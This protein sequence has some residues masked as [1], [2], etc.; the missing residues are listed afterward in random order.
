MTRLFI[1]VGPLRRF[2]QFRR[3]W[4]GY[5]FRQL[6][7]QLTATTVIYQVFIQTHS[8]IDVGL[9]SIAQLGP[10][11]L[12]PIIG[13]AIADAI[14]RR[15]LLVV[16]AVLFA[17]STTGLALNALGPRP[18]L[19]PLYVCSAIT[20]GLNG[21]DGPT[22]TAVTMSLVDRGSVVSANILRQVLGQTSNIAGPGLA[23]IL[24]ALFHHHLA[25]VYWIDA[26]S[27]VAALQAVLRLPPLMPGGGGRKFSFGSIAEGFRFLRGRQAIQACFLADFIATVLGEPIS[28][29]PYM[30]LV[31]FHGGPKAF[32]LLSASPAIGAGLGS[33][34]SGWTGTVHRPGRWVLIAVAIWGA[35]IVGFG[36]APW[37]WLGV[38]CV[39]I[40]G[41]ADATSV[42]F[43]TT[44][45]QLDVPDR[46]RGR[47]SSIQSMV[48]QSGPKLG[49][50][51]GGLVAG[52]ANAPIAIVSGGLGCLVGVALMAKF[53]PTFANYEIRSATDFQEDEESANTE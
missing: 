18:A 34:F 21:V 45:L 48:V 5:L 13:G 10:A 53:I 35:A 50:A 7:A 26:A 14:D 33:L 51:E 1:D 2:P 44:I 36:V 32:G 11:I 4:T 47:L 52:L 37:L 20:W 19:W 9:I 24:I 16:T 27:T 28:L 6:G 31:H 43:R 41:W 42:L 39:A 25:T 15:R 17:M 46:L 3:L 29:F 8:N 12:A 38:C 30:A 40:A 23:G 22:R 49:N